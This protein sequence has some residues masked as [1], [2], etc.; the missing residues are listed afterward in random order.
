MNAQSSVT[1]DPLPTRP[2]VGLVGFGYWGPNLARNFQAIP[3]CEFVAIADADPMRLAKAGELYRHVQLYPTAEALMA[4]DLD[5]V[6]IATPARTHYALAL[7]ALEAG[8]HVLVEK[9]LAMSSAE[10]QALI[11]A[12]AAR[13][14]VLMVGHVFEYNP[15]VRYIKDLLTAGVLGELYY[16]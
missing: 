2:R 10:A 14:R 1:R 12:A 3:D 4:A 11:A 13:Q 16:L 9:P 15:A 6:V 7:A 5:A 8:K